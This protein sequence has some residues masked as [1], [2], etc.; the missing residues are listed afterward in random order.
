MREIFDAFL[1]L[2]EEDE[3]VQPF[4]FI[5]ADRVD[6][7]KE[8]VLGVCLDVSQ[9][10]EGDVGVARC[11]VE[12]A[13]DWGMQILEG[14]V[15]FEEMKE[16][17]AANWDGEIQGED[18]GPEA[19]HAQ[20]AAEEGWQVG[21]HAPRERTMYGWYSLVEKGESAV[22]SCCC[23]GCADVAKP[24]LSTACSTLTGLTKHPSSAGSR[25][26]GTGSLRLIRGQISAGSI[27]DR[28]RF[29]QGFTGR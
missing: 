6:F 23:D 15:G 20:K 16:F 19:R 10:G 11:D 7:G 22:R 5:I 29:D 3:S 2:R 1:V 9:E 28:L 12:M 26:W 27:L 13:G 18:L 17:E 4:Y 8:G 25:C 24:C 14:V 21:N